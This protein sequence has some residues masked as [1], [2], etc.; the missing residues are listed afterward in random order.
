MR[1]S[2]RLTI[3]DLKHG[4]EKTYPLSIEV[5]LGSL[6]LSFARYLSTRVFHE[7]NLE[8]LPWDCCRSSG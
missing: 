8:H 2:P 4:R 3:T 1:P 6:V 7:G 5:N